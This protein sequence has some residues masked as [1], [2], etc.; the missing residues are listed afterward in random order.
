MTVPR[1][2]ALLFFV[3][4]SL[5]WYGCGGT[6]KPEGMPTLYPCTIKVTQD[7][8]PLAEAIVYLD[9]V[10]EKHKWPVSG[11]TNVQGVATLSAQAKYLGAFAGDYKLVVTKEE[12]FQ[13][14]PDQPVPGSDTEI[15]PGSPVIRYSLVESQYTSGKT[16]PQDVTVAKGTNN[17]TFDVGKAVREKM[18]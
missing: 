6:P 15:I 16:S 12:D 2:P 14:R 17:F 1:I 10:G 3:C 8:Q 7:G 5:T 18:K 9:P 4:L 13:E 11:V